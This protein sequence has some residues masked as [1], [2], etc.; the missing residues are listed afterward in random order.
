MAKGKLFELLKNAVDN[1][2]QNNRE[3]PNQKTAPGE[4]FKRM[5]EQ[6]GE[7]KELNQERK[8]EKLEERFER[9]EARLERK[10]EK[11]ELREQ[12]RGQKNEMKQGWQEST[13]VEKI[14]IEINP[15]ENTPAENPFDAVRR[16][17]EEIKKDNEVR[18]DEETAQPEMWDQLMKEVQVLESIPATKVEYSQ[19]AE[20]AGSAHNPWAASNTPPIG[21]GVIN[22]M[23]SIAINAEPN[24]GSE[25]SSF[26]L[27]Q[28]AVVSILAQ[29]N[30]NPINLDGQQC[31]WCKVHFEGKEGWILNAYLGSV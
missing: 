21:N 28:G 4:L 25:R 5:Q 23:G 12:F 16:K 22:A 31:G 26:R 24:M 29:D 13:P 6:L 15:I 17:I 19:P 27:P 9:K 18:E 2:Q 20:P 11:R 30:S 7:L 10:A 1:V 8:A 14:P 3:N